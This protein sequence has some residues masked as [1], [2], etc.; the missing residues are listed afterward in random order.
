[1]PMRTS[2]ETNHNLHP[3]WIAS[4]LIFVSLVFWVGVAQSGSHAPS[5]GSAQKDVLA[6]GGF[7]VDA[8]CD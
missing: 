6:T 8:E 5:S 3:K 4:S 7:V 1:M 2:V